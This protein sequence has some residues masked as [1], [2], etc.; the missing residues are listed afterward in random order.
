VNEFKR[1]SNLSSLVATRLSPHLATES[2]YKITRKNII[3]CH[4]Y[5]SLINFVNSAIKR[6][7]ASQ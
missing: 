1:T 7:N 2:F 6:I 5:P 3:F 4:N